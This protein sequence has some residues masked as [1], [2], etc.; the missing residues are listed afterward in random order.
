M[1]EHLLDCVNMS[2]HFLKNFLEK[3][4]ESR[5]HKEILDKVKNLREQIKTQKS[6]KQPILVEKKRPVA[7]KLLEPE[8]EDS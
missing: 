5:L 7:L 2:S 1:S 6:N 4:P 8:V 3:L